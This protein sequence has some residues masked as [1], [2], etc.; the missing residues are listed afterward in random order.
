MKYAGRSLWVLA[1]G[2]Q[3]KTSQQETGLG[4]LGEGYHVQEDSKCLFA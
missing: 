4:S 2:F 3:V 1:T